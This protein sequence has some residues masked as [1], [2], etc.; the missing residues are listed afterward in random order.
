M[1]IKQ[2][3]KL[4]QVHCKITLLRN[5]W[6]SPS[7][8]KTLYVLEND[9]VL[10]LQLMKNLPPSLISYAFVWEYVSHFKCELAGWKVSIHIL[11]ASEAPF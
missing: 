6:D 5:Q 3:M 2:I 4:M 11:F 10:K 9:P 1:N 7:L 8:W